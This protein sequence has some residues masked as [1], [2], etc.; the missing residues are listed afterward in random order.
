MD[1][2]VLMGSVVVAA[3]KDSLTAAVVVVTG[4]PPDA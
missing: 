4:W 2:A 1:S 3:V